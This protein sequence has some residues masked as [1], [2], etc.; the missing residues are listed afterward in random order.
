VLSDVRLAYCG[1][2]TRPIR[3]RIAERILE[4]R[5][6]GSAA[7]AEA[8]AALAEDL[9]PPDDLQATGQMKL[10]LSQVLAARVLPAMGRA[11]VR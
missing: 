2:D 8:K 3:A 11:D 4:G 7:L 1:V 6:F 5:P 10:H 9:D